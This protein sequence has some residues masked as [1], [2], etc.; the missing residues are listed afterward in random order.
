MPFF[1]TLARACVSLKQ[2]EIIHLSLSPIDIPFLFGSQCKAMQCE[3]GAL[4]Y[5]YC[6]CHYYYHYYYYLT[7]YSPSN[8]DPSDIALPSDSP[9]ALCPTAD[10]AENVGRDNRSPC[11]RFIN[12]LSGT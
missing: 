8:S 3:C 5:T 2:S 10:S 7:I 11:T 6:C 9:N 4:T 12:A 1:N